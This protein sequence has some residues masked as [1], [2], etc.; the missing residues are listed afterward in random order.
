MFGFSERKFYKDCEM[1]LEIAGIYM[2]C[3]VQHGFVDGLECG[4]HMEQIFHFFLNEVLPFVYS[5]CRGYKCIVVL[6][7]I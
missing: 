3:V 4:I 7:Y 2:L 6:C 1:S 5:Y